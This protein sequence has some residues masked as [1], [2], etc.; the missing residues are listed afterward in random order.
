MQIL[1]WKEVPVYNGGSWKQITDDGVY[2]A[3]GYLH[4]EWIK[5]FKHDEKNYQAV[6]VNHFPVQFASMGH[7]QPSQFGSGLTAIGG[8]MSQLLT[9]LR[10]LLD[11]PQVPPKGGGGGTGG[12]GVHHPPTYASLYEKINELAD[13]NSAQMSRFHTDKFDDFLYQEPRVNEL[14]EEIT[15]ESDFLAFE[16]ATKDNGQVHAEVV[17]ETIAAITGVVSLVGTVWGAISSMQ[18]DPGILQSPWG[19]YSNSDG[20]LTHIYSEWYQG[21]AVRLK[22]VWGNNERSVFIKKR[23]AQLQSMKDVRQLR[24]QAKG[25][26]PKIAKPGTVVSF[27]DF[28][29]MDVIKPKA[30]ES[31]KLPF[32]LAELKYFTGHNEIEPMDINPLTDCPFHVKDG[33]MR[34]RNYI[35]QYANEIQMLSSRIPSQHD[36]A[37]TLISSFA[38]DIGVILSAWGAVPPVGIGAGIFIAV[39]RLSRLEQDFELMALIAEVRTYKHAISEWGQYVERLRGSYPACF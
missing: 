12:G 35:Q 6:L 27:Q 18:N 39:N 29:K 26:L 7:S 14:I 5:T 38:I 24:D 30:K 17:F 9:Q 2:S 31:G 4:P 21:S 11:K 8:S 22:W 28:M 20:S 33:L 25:K 19:D 10:L 1:P 32:E 13:L 15:L 3:A 34:A 36:W 16:A 23:S 37:K